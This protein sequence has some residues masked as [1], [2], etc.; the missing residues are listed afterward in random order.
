MLYRIRVHFFLSDGK[1]PGLES[2]T[3]IMT[4]SALQLGMTLSNVNLVH[5]S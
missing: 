2:G 1:L 4:V 3:S 5:K